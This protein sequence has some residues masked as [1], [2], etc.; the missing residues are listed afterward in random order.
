MHTHVLQ[1]LK[2]SG[3]YL[4]RLLIIIRCKHLGHGLPAYWALSHGAPLMCAGAITRSSIC[5]SAGDAG[6]GGV[7]LRR[8]ALSVAD[9]QDGGACFQHHCTE[10]GRDC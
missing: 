8:S 3:V 2:G 7:D 10:G 4:S 6:Q 1:R 5:V 9:A